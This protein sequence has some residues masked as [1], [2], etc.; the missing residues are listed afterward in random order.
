M[1]SPALRVVIAQVELHALHV[2][3]VGDGFGV[4]Q[5]TG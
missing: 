5:A 4:Q 1:I 3:F 2:R